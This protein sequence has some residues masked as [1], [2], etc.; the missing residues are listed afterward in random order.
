MSDP[1]VS[2]PAASNPAVSDPAITNLDRW[3]TTNEHYLTA[4][5]AW[6]RLR[7]TQTIEATI[8]APAPRP[9]SPASPSSSSSAPPPPPPSADPPPALILLSQQFQLS[10]F[11][12]NLLL[13]CAA[14]ELDTQTATLCATIHDNATWRYPT[15]ALALSC[16]DNP[17][18]DA[19]SPERPLRYWRLL[20]IHQSGAQPLTSSPLRIDERIL[21]YIKGLN[22]VDDR[23]TPFLA[24]LD[25]VPRSI[26]LPPSQQA[27]AD[28]ILQTLTAS[29][30]WSR[31]PSLQLVGSDSLS[32]QLVVQQ[33]AQQLGVHLYR[34]PLEL[35]PSQTNDLETLARLWQR[36]SLLLPLALFVDAHEAEFNSSEGRALSLQRFLTRSGG[37]FFLS[38]R[39]VRQGLTT[40]SHGFD[41]DKPT[42][43]EQQ[44]LWQQVLG[45]AADHAPLLAS[46]FN[47]NLLT[48]HS[49]A[50]RVLSIPPASNQEP[51][52]LADRLWQA[53]LAHSRPQLDTLAQR[54]DV[55]ATWE[56]LVLPQEEKNLLR[57]IIEQVQY[58]SVV[59]QDWGFQQRM[60]R[61][62]GISA[63]FAGE[64]GTGKTMAAEVIAHELQLN[65][66]RIDLSAVVSKYIGE[67]EKNLRRLF[68]AA[69]DGGT[70]LF[71]DEA[72]ALFGK[73]S[74]VKDSHDRYAN[75]E[76]NYLLQRME[77]Y[78]GL[79]ILATNLKGS[80]DTAFMRRL[81]FI[82]NFPF[83][84]IPERD[85]IW[86]K[87]FP[88]QT[89]VQ[90]L[91]YRRLAKLNL[92]G[93]SI[94]NVALNATFLAAQTQTPVTMPLVLSAARTEFRKLDR[95]INEAD[96]R[97]HTSPEDQS[98]QGK[99]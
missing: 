53:C 87:A 98:P 31:S 33:V 2:D 73:R 97:W 75:I 41:V 1:A 21:N 84:G 8:D 15:F 81:R 34:L 28:A 65:L 67:T 42:P 36:E 20:E 58:R 70:I 32:K 25:A 96:F 82:V 24:P 10:P 94:H 63:L 90:D 13:L 57:Q 4:A 3:H 95:P 37:L 23:L 85:I 80:L 66:Y 79:A 68:D 18:W 49:L 77:S 56:L 46:Q 19:L 35:L 64:S 72:D 59:Y 48:I 86:Q 62:L 27:V 99:L 9:A 16:F 78:R 43:G 29:N 55:K 76:I 30:Q 52:S 61:G 22:Y 26:A 11:E 51:V 50:H 7:L 44:T 91:N 93:G 92:T 6:L 88:A 89:P 38:L 40:A 39:E 71:F 83:P 17:A 69:E 60:N 47:F 54:L 45:T 12:Q 5:L 14:M 74:E